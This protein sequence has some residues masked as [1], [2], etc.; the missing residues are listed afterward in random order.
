VDRRK[1]ELTSETKEHKNGTTLYRIRATV[2]L[3]HHNVVRGELGGYIQHT[4][5]L[6]GKAW[7]SHNAEV[8]EDAR[9]SGK[10]L[11]SNFAKVFGAARVRDEAHVSQSAYVSGNAVVEGQAHVSG[12]AVVRE[13]AWVYDDAQIY[14]NTRVRGAA[15]VY[16]WADVSGYARIIGDARVCQHAVV[17]GKACIAKSAHIFGMARIHGNAHTHGKVEISGSDEI[18]GTADINTAEQLEEHIYSVTPPSFIRYLDYIS[19]KTFGE[20]HI[21]IGLPNNVFQIIVPGAPPQLVQE[22]LAPAIQQF[23]LAQYIP[24]EWEG[25]TLTIKHLP[26][27]NAKL[28]DG[29]GHIPKRAYTASSRAVQSLREYLT[30]REGG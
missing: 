25:D 28:M 18:G 29:G 11:A 19:E 23:D 26:K 2:D 27:I 17:T 9:I 24:D 6:I 10:A 15:Q 12:S 1:Y 16:G 13:D 21:K 4:D 5:N 3:P 14:G 22:F 20:Y 30:R 7:V 8:F